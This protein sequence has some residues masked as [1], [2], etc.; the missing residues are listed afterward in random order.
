MRYLAILTVASISASLSGCTTTQ[1]TPEGRE[2]RITE[3][4]DVVKNCKLIGPVKGE[5][6]MLGGIFLQATAE[7][8]A[9]R[10]LANVAASMGA[11]TVLITTPDT[12]MMGSSMSGQA[13]SCAKASG[14]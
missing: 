14:S 12:G 5:D 3:K 4:P 7:V 8:N 1:F 11:D 6:H 2:V 10:R 9:T 13:Y